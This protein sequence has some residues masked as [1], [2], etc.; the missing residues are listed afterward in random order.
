M[1]KL[2]IIV[3]FISSCVLSQTQDIQH[4]E[5]NDIGIQFPDEIPIAGELNWKPAIPG[6]QVALLDVMFH[7][8]LVDRILLARTDPAKFKI[9]VHCAPH[10]N[11]KYLHEWR[12]ELNAN[13]VINGSFYTRET[14]A[15]AYGEPDV[16]MLINRKVMGKK[17]YWSRHAAFLLGPLNESDPLVKVVDYQPKAKV[18]FEKE[19]YT[20]GTI[21]FPTL[22]DFD[23]NTRAPRSPKKRATRSFIALDKNQYLILGNTQGGFFSL[24]RL[25][26][27]LASVKE[28]NIAYALNLDGGPPANMLIDTGDIFYEQYGVWETSPD[29][30]D[31]EIFSWNDNNFTKW[32]NPIVIAITKR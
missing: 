26:K 5:P 32:K 9:S 21:S 16:P 25:G 31:N 6:L 8:I 4:I 3:F 27:F 23:G 1:L 10:P 29:D 18:E 7:E 2:F 24:I 22:V 15:T 19:M 11:M 12:N 20:D 30:N 17:N 13:V 14:N 28:L